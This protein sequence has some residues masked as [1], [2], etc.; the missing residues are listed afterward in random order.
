MKELP[1]FKDQGFFSP[2]LL[3]GIQALVPAYKLS[4]TGTLIRWRVA[5]AREGQH[6][7]HLQV[8]RP[9]SEPDSYSKVGSNTFNLKPTSGQR[10]FT[11]TP[12]YKDQIRVQVGDVL[13]FYLEKNN[14]DDFSIQYQA[15]VSGIS[16]LYRQV[17]GTLQTINHYTLPVELLNAAP[18]IQ[19][20]IGES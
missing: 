12:S 15:R 6:N 18:I 7:I 17:S 20:E 2:M 5:T 9:G 19:A 14:S 16:V 10:L 13:G 4:C 8:W 11:L 3:V 1:L